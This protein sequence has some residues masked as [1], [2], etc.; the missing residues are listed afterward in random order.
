MMTGMMWLREEQVLC[1]EQ[2]NHPN[3]GMASKRYKSTSE[4]RAGIS[5]KGRLGRGYRSQ[6]GE[7]CFHSRS[8]VGCLQS[9]QGRDK[10]PKAGLKRQGKRHKALRM[11]HF[12]QRTVENL[13]RA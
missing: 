4:G 5:W 13:Q 12:I 9:G 6:K 7:K 8:G 11:F 3:L 10:G 2:Q 1:G